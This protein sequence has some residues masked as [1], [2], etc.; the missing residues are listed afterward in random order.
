MQSEPWNII[1]RKLRQSV[2][3]RLDSHVSAHLKQR[4]STAIREGPQSKVTTNKSAG[5]HQIVAGFPIYSTSC[6]QL[7][8]KGINDRQASGWLLLI[9]SPQGVT[10]QVEA[11]ASGKGF[12]VIRV[13]TGAIVDQLKKAL[14]R[15]RTLITRRRRSSLQFRA[16]RVS[17]MHI[18]AVWIHQCRR[19]EQDVVIPFTANFAGLREHR[20]Y[21]RRT[22]E[23]VLKV[24][25]TSMI[26]RWYEKQTAHDESRIPY[27]GH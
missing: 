21:K 8:R 19:P 7:A 26:I 12:V 17:A 13:S 9:D 2:G 10:L 20:S 14:V 11:K 27:L 1:P 22:A 3:E 18:F 24:V 6:G 4:Q 5:K 23:R 25:A 15:A 16:L